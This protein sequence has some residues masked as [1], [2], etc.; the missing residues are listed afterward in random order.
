MLQHSVLGNWILSQGQCIVKKRESA[1]YIQL[2]G[3]MLWL[4]AASY[5]TT[6]VGATAVPHST[7]LYN[8]EAWFS[9]WPTLYFLI[10]WTIGFS[11]VLCVVLLFTAKY[12]SC[13]ISQSDHCIFTCL[14][15]LLVRYN[16][17]FSRGLY[18]FSGYSSFLLSGHSIHFHLLNLYLIPHTIRFHF[19]SNNSHPYK[20]LLG[21]SPKRSNDS[22]H[23]EI[24]VDKR[25]DAK[26]KSA[27]S[28]FGK[29]SDPNP[30][31]CTQNLYI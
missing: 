27:G 8:I 23:G 24:W 31:S 25:K 28:Q 16:P 7:F 13:S 5:V 10:K 29:F 9:K 14:I 4:S 15:N 1:K 21:P 22:G 11:P 30:P 17:L 26:Q 2:K 3:A 18:W 6:T 20:H 12:S 19:F